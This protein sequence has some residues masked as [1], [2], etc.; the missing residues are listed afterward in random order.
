MHNL[1]DKYGA[2]V[3]A[4][5]I[6]G[7]HQRVLA[8]PKLRAMFEGLPPEDV[9]GHQIKL[10][11]FAMGKPHQRYTSA[12]MARDH[13]RLRLRT[14]EYE[15]LMHALQETL[16]EARVDYKDA[17]QIFSAIDRH[18]TDLVAAAVR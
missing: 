8:S 13:H 17:R 5:V 12:D 9:I 10:I 11:A 1:F 14:A 3:I 18:R 2:A 15:E 6:R 7:F 16:L 4:D